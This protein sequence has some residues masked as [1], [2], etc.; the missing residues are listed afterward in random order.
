MNNKLK[1]YILIFFLG[2]FVGFIYEVIFYFLT[3]NRLDNA[4]ILYGPWLPIYGLGAILITLLP[5]KLKKKPILL[6]LSIILTTGILEYF[7]GYIDLKF[8]HERLWDYRGLFLN[9]NGFV[10]LRSV[11]T[12]AVGGLALVYLIEPFINKLLDNKKYQKIISGILLILIFIF[13]ID[14]FLSNIFNRTP[15][16]Y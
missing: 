12:F 8:F 3:E 4:G 11:L 9:I 1:K 16:L 5:S 2:A 10:C 14:I 6:F 13:I 7:I 15:Y